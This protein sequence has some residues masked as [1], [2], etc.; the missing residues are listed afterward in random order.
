MHNRDILS[1]FFNMKVYCVFSLESPHRGDFNVY[2]QYTIFVR[3]TKIT[4]DN[5]KSAAMGFFLGT[6]E[7]VRNSRDKRAISVRATEVLLYL[8]DFDFVNNDALSWSEKQH[9]L[10]KEEDPALSRGHLCTQNSKH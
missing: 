8:Q 2:K 10:C 5:S 6:Q 3:K 7:R 1:I 9:R 4:P